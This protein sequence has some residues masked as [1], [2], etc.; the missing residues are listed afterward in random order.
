MDAIIK[1]NIR[2]KVSKRTNLARKHNA[3][4]NYKG[5]CV[6]FRRRTDKKILKVSLGKQFIH[7]QKTLLFYLI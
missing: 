1:Q 7:Q 5:F 6:A 3:Q 4:C 2:R